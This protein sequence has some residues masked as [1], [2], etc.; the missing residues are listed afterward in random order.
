MMKTRFGV[1]PVYNAQAM[2]SP[3]DPEGEGGSVLITAV[4]LVDEP[5]DYGQLTPMLERA[6]ETTG[7]KAGMTLA[8]GGYHSGR[9]LEECARRGQAV[10]MPQAPRR[11]SAEHPYHR[12]NFTYD[13]ENDSYIC[14]HG[15]TL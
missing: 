2:V 6:E 1:L 13:Q 11:R 4:D 10:A 7:S 15:Q 5:N 9:N 3:F 14:P 8:D 12:Y